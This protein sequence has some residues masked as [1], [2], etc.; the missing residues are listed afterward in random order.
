MKTAVI[1]MMLLLVASAS[2]ASVTDT[3]AVGEFKTYEVGGKAYEVG[4]KD[5][6]Q[7]ATFI[8]NGEKLVL[9]PTEAV[10]AADGA[11]FFLEG[12]SMLMGV[13][14]ETAT[15]TLR[16]QEGACA[17]TDGGKNYRVQGTATGRQDGKEVIST[18]AC[19]Y[20]GKSLVEMYCEN[21]KVMKEQYACPG[22][23]RNGA[24][25]LA[26]EPL[27]KCTV[28]AD[29]RQIESI[30]STEAMCEEEVYE[31]SPAVWCQDAM[32][33]MGYLPKDVKFTWGGET[34][35]QFTCSEAVPVASCKDSDGGENYYVAGE[36]TE[37]N[38]YTD[39][40]PNTYRDTCVEDVD[41][42][43]LAEA[44]CVR[45]GGQ[46]V[47]SQVY[48][49][50]PMGCRNGA[51]VRE[52]PAKLG[53]CSFLLNGRELES[54][55]ATLETCKDEV[56]EINTIDACREIREDY[57]VLKAEVE[58]LW[59]DELLKSFT[60]APLEE[61]P[62]GRCEFIFDGTV[63][64][65]LEATREFCMDEAYELIPEA[66]CPR[67]LKKLGEPEVSVEARW[68]GHAL[69]S[70]ECSIPV[71]E[72]PLGICAMSVGGRLVVQSDERMARHYCEERWRP[73]YVV[74]S[75]I[76][77]CRRNRDGDVRVLWDG[78]V[79]ETERATCAE[80]L[81]GPPV[82]PPE[83]VLPE[84]RCDGCRLNGR[85]VVVGTVAEGKFCS[86]ESTWEKLKA[87]GSKCGQHWEC[88]GG[89]CADGQC[90][91]PGLLQRF[92]RWVGGWFG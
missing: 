24:C 19:R 73:E 39:F 79:I 71:A 86:M 43:N 57:G 59:N 64:E 72:G 62:V 44:V 14:L 88:Q 41:D 27:Y 48:Y 63:F 12:I 37:K 87:E 33:E 6:G 65:S 80:V 82:Q 13:G 30:E 92:L 49:N 2:A 16:R 52:Q 70:F 77:A 20:D 69:R 42:A 89:I 32:S 18:D 7:E 56:E 8:V 11:R 74:D 40:L 61:E 23:C 60:C 68:N 45:R 54:R 9:V 50:C 83:P 25:V 21:G 51:C 85:C 36:V 4:L 10:I 22:V 46:V 53:K 66:Y 75:V 67:V 28:W 81:E 35:R 55:E 91:S 78:E 76:K 38:R 34:V 29:G 3:L 5:V 47:G 15:F 26:E 17:D 58:V 90:I 1:L 31:I 84:P